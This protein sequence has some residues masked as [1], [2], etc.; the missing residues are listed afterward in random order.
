MHSESPIWDAFQFK[1]FEYEPL[2]SANFIRLLEIHREEV[3]IPIRPG[4]HEIVNHSK[5]RG[6]SISGVPLLPCSLRSVNLD[7]HPSYNALS[8]TWG[9]PMADDSSPSHGLDHICGEQRPSPL[10]KQD[11]DELPS[12]EVKHYTWCIPQERD[13]LFAAEY[14]L[15]Q[16][17][18]IACNN[19]IL[20]VTKNLYEALCQLGKPCIREERDQI[21]NKTALIMAAERGQ[22]GLVETLL[23]KGASVESQDLF[24]ETAMHYAAENG[25]LGVVKLLAQA[26]T[27]I[28]TRDRSNRTPLECSL[29]RN[30]REV[31]EFLLDISQDAKSTRP[32]TSANITPNLLWVDAV[33]IDQE[34]VFE[35]SAQV[36]I[37]WNV[38]R[39]ASQSIIWLGKD[40]EDSET[41]KTF[42]T[43][44]AATSNGN[45]HKLE[46]SSSIDDIEFFSKLGIP[47][48][49]MQRWGCLVRFLR[50]SWFRRAWIVQEVVLARKLRVLCGSLEMDWDDIAKAINFLSTNTNLE[51]MWRVRQKIDLSRTHL[52]KEHFQLIK[53]LRTAHQGG[54]TYNLLVMV[55]KTLGSLSTN[56]RDKIY[57][58]LGL[59]CQSPWFLGNCHC[60]EITPD[61]SRSVPQV[62]TEA[63]RAMLQSNQNLSLLSIAG[64]VRNPNIPDLPSWVPNYTLP[65][66]HAPV[67]RW[68]KF[69]VHTDSDETSTLFSLTSPHGAERVLGLRAARWDTVRDVGAE[70]QSVRSD[71]LSLS[72]TSW[73]NLITRLP[74]IYHNGQNRVEALWR[75]LIAYNRENGPANSTDLRPAFHDAILWWMLKHI[76][77]VIRNDPEN[78][79]WRSEGVDAPALATVAD[80]A[81]L[82]D[83]DPD[84]TIPTLSDWKE[85]WAW[86][87][88]VSKG[89]EQS[90]S[91][92]FYRAQ[93]LMQALNNNICS[94]R[95]IVTANGYLGLGPEQI[96][97]G[98]S[99]WIL[100]GGNVPFYLRRKKDNGRCLLLGAAYVY[101]IM[102]GETLEWDRL[103]FEDVELE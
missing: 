58:L 3:V 32:P 59:C 67:S 55:N 87:M 77:D 1:A 25:H 94:R 5:A 47:H 86:W 49:S 91:D 76:A 79:S 100:P 65:L 38:Y 60:P 102:Y 71:G 39:S 97:A 44:L 63:T 84:G 17:W 37:M 8:Y 36:N 16:K 45:L 92:P 19:R 56:P 78:N 50:R 72:F 75:T 89:G 61:Y 74:V 96:Q 31:T 62:F 53:M 22:K 70:V 80:L 20:Y 57:A 21:Y 98:D 66:D 27:D 4:S 28:N 69:N 9:N 68:A 11:V 54:G 26:G 13:A 90:S 6:P 103:N 14:A 85:Y 30:R 34:N 82:A 51:F 29:Q 7:D 81:T 83:S 73:T 23:A 95:L 48:F 33:C 2:Q 15:D 43:Q 24:G 46:L 10:L 42:I 35:R 93:P 64:L 88:K 99:I 12:Y 40:D 52:L 101:G 18:P 41:A